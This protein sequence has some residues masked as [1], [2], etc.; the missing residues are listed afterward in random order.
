MDVA[1][2]KIARI[3]WNKLINFEPDVLYC[4]FLALVF[5]FIISS[6][7]L[8]DLLVLSFVWNGLYEA[9]TLICC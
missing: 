5:I 6:I 7:L 8:V 1:F 3:Y 9:L 4:H 2:P